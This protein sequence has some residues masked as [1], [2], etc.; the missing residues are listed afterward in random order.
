MIMLTTAVPAAGRGRNAAGDLGGRCRVEIGS[1][2]SVGAAQAACE[3]DAERRARS[4]TVA[5]TGGNHGHRPHRAARWRL[6]RTVRSHA[7]PWRARMAA[8]N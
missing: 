8:A 4:V 7:R 1:F 5:V 6:V 2:G 3:R